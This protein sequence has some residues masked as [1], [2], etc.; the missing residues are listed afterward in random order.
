[1]LDKHGSLWCCWY[2]N[3]AKVPTHN[4]A[5]RDSSNMHL[6]MERER[7]D[8]PHTIQRRGD[9]KQQKTSLA[10]WLVRARTWARTRARAHTH[11]HTHTHR[12]SKDR[13]QGVCNWYY[14][15]G[16]K[17]GI[18]STERVERGRLDRS[19]IKSGKQPRQPY[20][21]VRSFIAD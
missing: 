13:K 9:Q 2:M 17:A 21:H 1:M 6:L 14:R 19:V 7:G 15:N 10:E 16:N 12:E 18:S 5:V 20:L 11:T 8:S 4:T 3:M